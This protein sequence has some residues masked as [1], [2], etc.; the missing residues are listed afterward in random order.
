MAKIWQDEICLSWKHIRLGTINVTKIS[1]SKCDSS[2]TF[3]LQMPPTYP[4]CTFAFAGVKWLFAFG[5]RHW[6]TLPF[7]AQQC[8]HLNP[9]MFL[10]FIFDLISNPI[11]SM[12]RR[13]SQTN[14]W[15][16]KPDFGDIFPPLIITSQKCDTPSLLLLSFILVAAA[17]M[18]IASTQL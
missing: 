16:E 11:L 8:A 15:P 5:N 6:C 9:N 17:V 2:A 14:F 12:F 13:G 3:Q 18:P 4:H 7:H 10:L 1:W